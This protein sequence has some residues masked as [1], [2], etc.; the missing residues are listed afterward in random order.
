[1]GLP[2]QLTVVED[3]KRDLNVSKDRRKLAESPEM[4]RN[5]AN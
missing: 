1:M 2:S 3:S 5:V 4:F